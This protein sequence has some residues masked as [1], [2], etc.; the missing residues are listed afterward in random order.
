[1]MRSSLWF[2]FSFLLVMQAL[3]SDKGPEKFLPPG[4][5]DWKPV[6]PDRYY[7]PDNLFD[8]I[9][10]GAE[11]YLS[12]GFREVLSRRYECPGKPYIQVEI[13]DMI[14]PA[15][16]YGI[17]TQTREKEGSEYGQGSQVLPGAVLFWKGPY[18]ISVISEYETP[19]SEEM[20]RWLAATIDHRIAAS[21]EMPPV[22][23]AL[24]RNGLDEGSVVYFRHYVWANR[25]YYIADGNVFG[26]ENDTHCCLGR[27]ASPQGSYYVLLMDF[28]SGE[29]V[30]AAWLGYW[31]ERAGET[32]PLTEQEGGRWH[33]GHRVGSMMA[34]VFRAPDRDTALKTLA[35]IF[36]SE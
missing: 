17:Y 36:P 18:Y 26:I 28:P 9:N 23:R 5:G 3:A 25:Y 15:N 16:A 13:F 24:P 21:G 14:E 30:K 29:R 11:L 4:A 33:A 20:I 19:E 8:Y 1:M 35:E 22:V 10:G 6:E 31:E 27:Y 12:Y 34:M 2:F 7:Q 32:S